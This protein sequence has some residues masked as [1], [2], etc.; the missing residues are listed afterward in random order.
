MFFRAFRQKPQDAGKPAK[1]ALTAT[2]RR[3][4]GMCNSM[5]ADGT[6]LREGQPA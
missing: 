4:A 5:I 1:A 3:L 6:C 2:A